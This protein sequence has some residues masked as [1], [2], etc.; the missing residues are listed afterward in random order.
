MSPE[1]AYLVIGHYIICSVC[2]F[3]I[4]AMGAVISYFKKH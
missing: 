3:V 2:L 1:T 4:A